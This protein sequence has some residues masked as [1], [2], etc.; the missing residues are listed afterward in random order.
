MDFPDSLL[1][2]ISIIHRFRYVFETTSIC[3]S[4]HQ[5]SEYG[6]RLNF[7]WVQVQG[8]SPDMPGK[9]KNTSSPIGITL[10]RALLRLQ[11]GEIAS[12]GSRIWVS[13]DYKT[14]LLEWTSDHITQSRPTMTPTTTTDRNQLCTQNICSEKV[15]YL[16]RSVVYIYICIYMYIYPPYMYIY[17]YMVWFGLVLW[18]IKHC[19]LLMPNPFLYL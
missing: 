4:P 1:P 15:L 14:W 9:H 16:Y 12:W 5:M 13:L 7:R 2:F 17:I 11:P 6:T 10:K 18:Q 3:H 8:C 19:K